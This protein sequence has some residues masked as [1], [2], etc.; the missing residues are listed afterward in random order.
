[1]TDRPNLLGP[2]TYHPNLDA[3]RFAACRTRMLTTTPANVSIAVVG[4]Q[5]FDALFPSATSNDGTLE[6][7]TYVAH[8]DASE[9]VAHYFTCHRGD[10]L[11]LG[12]QTITPTESTP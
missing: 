3:G 4:P 9:G 1:M 6:G 10:Y 7:L 2:L 11:P 12:A 8:V 5:T